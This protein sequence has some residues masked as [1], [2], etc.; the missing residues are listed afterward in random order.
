LL[1]AGETVTVQQLNPGTLHPFGTPA[2]T[3]FD[4]GGTAFYQAGLGTHWRGP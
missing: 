2:T 1:I 4:R 3:Y